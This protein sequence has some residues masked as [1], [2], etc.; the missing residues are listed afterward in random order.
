MSLLWLVFMYIRPRTRLVV[1]ISSAVLAFSL[2]SCAFSPVS[3][4]NWRPC[5]N[6]KRPTRVLSEPLSVSLVYVFPLGR[7]SVISQLLSTVRSTIPACYVRRSTSLVLFLIS[8]PEICQVM[9]S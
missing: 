9:Q 4:S 1:I 5:V 6:D 3:D 8:A 7:L 2:V